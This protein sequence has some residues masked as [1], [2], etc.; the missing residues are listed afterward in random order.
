MEDCVR[1]GGSKISML[2]PACS[3]KFHPLR[4]IHHLFLGTNIKFARIYLRCN[5]FAM[6]NQSSSLYWTSISNEIFKCCHREK[7]PFG[8]IDHVERCKSQTGI[9]SEYLSE[10]RWICLPNNLWEKKLIRVFF[11]LSSKLFFEKQPKQKYFN[12]WGKCKYA[13]QT[14]L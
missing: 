6:I 7:I 12:L 5:A 2:T 9:C 14:G 4:L 11:K 10:K 3:G 1:H 13:F 8:A